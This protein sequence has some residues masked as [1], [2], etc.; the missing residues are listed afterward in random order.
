M[1][2]CTKSPAPA[3][4][5]LTSD[6]TPPITF[7]PLSDNRATACTSACAG[8]DLRKVRHEIALEP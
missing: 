7:G 1:E 6:N 3:K 2:V 5:L 4:T 8:L